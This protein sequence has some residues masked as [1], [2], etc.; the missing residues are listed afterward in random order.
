MARA[1]RRRTALQLTAV[2]LREV[3]AALRSAA[4][5]VAPPSPLPSSQPTPGRP[6]VV[7]VHGYLG[8][9]HQLRPLAAALLRDGAP[10]A[11]FVSYP[12]AT[13]TL[14]AIVD[15]IARVCL[16]LRRVHGPVDLVGHSLGAL[17]CRHWIKRFGGATHVRR[18]VSVG[19]P[20]RGTE[21]YRLVPSPLRGVFNPRSPLLQAVN[22]TPEPVPTTVVRA[23]WDH[24]VV[25]PHHARIDGAQVD[26]VVQAWGHNALLWSPQAHAAVSRA[27]QLD[28]SHDSAHAP[29]PH[30]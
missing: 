2:S 30:A 12:S 6:P 5:I 9:P 1:G 20:H 25:P 17:A 19:G 8:H 13:A 7:L 16:P 26:E 28:P 3:G 10:S 29:L 18:F 14:D 22:Q 11:H 23:R 27:L 15:A 4:M 24:Q 21:L